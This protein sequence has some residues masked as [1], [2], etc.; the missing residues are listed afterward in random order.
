LEALEKVAESKPDIILLD[1]LMPGMDGFQTCRHLR[2]NPETKDVSIIFC[3]ATHIEEVKK[4][5]VAVDAYL[6]KPFSIEKLCE[7]I[8]EIL[9]LK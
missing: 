6:E 3:S 8:D 2:E 7:K 1:G 4:R 9:E 5:K